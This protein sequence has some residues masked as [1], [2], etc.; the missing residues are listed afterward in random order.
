MEIGQQVVDLLLTENLGVAGHLIAAETDH[1]GDAIVIGGHAAHGQILPL[2]DAFHA[3]TLPFPRRVGRMAAVAIVVVDPAAS[4][5]LGI[6]SEFGI[7]PA[8][9]DVAACERQDTHH[10]DAET[11][12]RPFRIFDTVLSTE[13]NARLLHPPFKQTATI[14]K[15]SYGQRGEPQ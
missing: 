11:Q 6:E 2:E 9:L 1:V 14:I 12:S 13:E 15:Q 7:A 4:D 8:A 10:R 3:G 5:L